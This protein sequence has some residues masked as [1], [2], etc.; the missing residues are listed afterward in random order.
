MFI[1]PEMQVTKK[2]KPKIATQTLHGLIHHA[3]EVSQREQANLC[4]TQ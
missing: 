4:Y 3:V 1:T 2:T